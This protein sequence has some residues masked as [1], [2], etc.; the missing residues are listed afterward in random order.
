MSR[1]RRDGPGTGDGDP[2]R[3]RLRT[4]ST[5]YFGVAE[6]DGVSAPR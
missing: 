5:D 2:R 6:A 3:K 4:G 1:T